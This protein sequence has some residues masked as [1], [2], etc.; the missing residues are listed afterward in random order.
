MDDY[1]QK[2]CPR[3]HFSDIKKNGHKRYRQRYRCRLCNHEWLDGRGGTRK[4]YCRYYLEWLHGRRTLAEI[5]NTLSMS[6]PTL[7]KHFDALDFPEGLLVPAPSKSINLIVDA[8]FFGRDYG[9]LCFHDT[10]RVIWFCEIRTE[11]VRHLREGLRTLLEVGYTFKSVTIDGRRGYMQAIRKL[12][13]PVPIQMCLYHQKAIVR[14]YISDRPQS[15][16]GQELQ[17]LMQ[18]LCFAEPDVFVDAFYRWKTEHRC[19][20]EARNA[21][22][23]YAHQN[24]RAAA[25]SV[26][27]NLH[28]LFTYKDI[29]DAG[30]PPTINHLEGM[31][32]HLKE[33][34][35]C[36]RGL[37]PH[38]K[39]KAVR[40]FLSTF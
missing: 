34:I 21:Q 19:F 28:A 8:T 7:Q 9:F 6:L 13:G 26:Q 40:A 20:L 5:S 1:E 23:D 16:A 22:R 30:I 2:S 37:S 17:A 15:Q 11:S 33:R 3:C 29:P 35:K 24:L 39:K 18:R 31:F 36:H 27:E 25:R 4:N 12:L 14:R 38:R 32:A 10:R